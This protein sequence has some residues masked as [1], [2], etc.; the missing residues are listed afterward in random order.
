MKYLDFSSLFDGDQAYIALFSTFQF[1]P[2]FFEKRLLRCLTLKKARR[3]AVFMDA[4]RMAG[5]VES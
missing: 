1:D 4:R 3:I 5:V 2:N